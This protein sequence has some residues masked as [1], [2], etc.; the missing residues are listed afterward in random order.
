MATGCAD[1]RVVCWDVDT[2]TVAQDLAINGHVKAVT[3]LSWSK[4]GQIL[5]SGSLDWTIRVWEIGGK[6]ERKKK[7]KNKKF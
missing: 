2:R 5:L 7:I 1:G 3:A 4:R 6:E